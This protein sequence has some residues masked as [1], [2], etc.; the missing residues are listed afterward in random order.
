MRKVLPRFLLLLLA[1]SMSF[2]VLAQAENTGA[3]AALPAEPVASATPAPVVYTSIESLDDKRK[4]QIG[5][6][7]SYRVIED[8]NP[9]V[10]L[11]VTDAGDIEV[12]LLGRVS[13]AGKT[14]RQLAYAVKPGAEKPIFTRPP[15]SWRWT[16]PR[17]NRRAASM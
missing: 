15:S 5:D 2:A 4:L 14:C 8:K 16:W 9:A 11:V 10:S 13:A 1:A 3:P 12:P 7:I 17:R 6:H